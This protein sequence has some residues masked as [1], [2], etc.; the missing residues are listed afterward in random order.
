MKNSQQLISSFLF[1][2]IFTF[3]ALAQSDEGR[4]KIDKIEAAEVKNPDYN[5]RVSDTRRGGDGPAKEWLELRCDYVTEAEWSD[6]ITLEY[7]VLF[8]SSSTKNTKK[9]DN[10]FKGVVT[11]SDVMKGEHTS[12]MHVHPHVFYRYGKVKAFSVTVK[13]GGKPIAHEGEPSSAKYEWWN[14][15]LPES[16][17]LL[18]RNETPFRW[19]EYN[20][21]ELIVEPAK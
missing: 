9:K 6:S 11:Y 18:K 1:A 3:G 4:V 13:R 2:A 21:Y 14:K 5:L 19:H 10:L 8:E 17:K 20:A 16:G 7:H 12:T 15:F